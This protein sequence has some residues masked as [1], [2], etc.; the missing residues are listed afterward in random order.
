VDIDNGRG[1]TFGNC[2]SGNSG[3]R[4]SYLP[5]YIHLYIPL[6]QVSS[7]KHGPQKVDPQGYQVMY[8]ELQ[9]SNYILLYG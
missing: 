3:G 2:G 7:I 8:I 4:L 6:K 9:V 1:L 5:T